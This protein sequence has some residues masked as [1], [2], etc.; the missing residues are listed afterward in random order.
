MRAGGESKVSVLRRIAD[1]LAKGRSERVTTGHLLAAIAKK[2]GMP[3]DLLRERRLD[4]DV[5]L[6]AARVVT[7]DSPDAVKVALERAREFAARS[8][9][10]EPSALHVLFALCQERKTAAHRAI[11]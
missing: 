6:R 11:E 8:G 4:E 7:D 2:G 3:A 1:E 5:L 10:R 9:A